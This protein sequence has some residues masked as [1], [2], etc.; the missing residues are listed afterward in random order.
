MLWAKDQ[1]SHFR[2]RRHDIVLTVASIQICQPGGSAPAAP[3][4]VEAF[5]PTSRKFS[6]HDVGLGRAGSYCSRLTSEPTPPVHYIGV[7][8]PHH[9][10]VSQVFKVVGAN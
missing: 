5:T 2:I 3:S 4:I 1:Y 8:W 10:F 7:N 6:G 9:I